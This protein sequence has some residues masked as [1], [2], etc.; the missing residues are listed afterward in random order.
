M[1][2]DDTTPNYI[3][4]ILNAFKKIEELQA[5]RDKLDAEMVK[6]EQ[7]IS[8]T[9][10]FLPDNERDVVM[11]RMRSGQTLQKIRESGLTDA[12]RIVLKK[13]TESLTTAQVRDRLIQLGFDFAFYSTNPL[14]SIS[15]TLRR[16]KDEDVETRITG[17]GVATYRWIGPL[18]PSLLQ[19]I[20]A[21][22]AEKGKPKFKL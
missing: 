15:T 3:A 2:I 10:N 22:E 20:K 7:F 16:M 6:Q 9:A 14:A 19:K 4:L 8:A 1:D 21:K 17:D 18:G 5:K 11:D 12:I 13:A